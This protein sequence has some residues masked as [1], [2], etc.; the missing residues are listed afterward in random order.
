MATP[1]WF[2]QRVPYRFLIN[3]ISLNHMMSNKI[4]ALLSRREIRDTFDIEFLIRQGISLPTES[5]IRS[6][7][8]SAVQSFSKKDFRVKLGSILPVDTRAYYK[9][10]GFVILEKH[11]R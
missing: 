1:F 5:D 7:V 9:D 8:M 10:A 3:T 2:G 4:E 6:K 11:L